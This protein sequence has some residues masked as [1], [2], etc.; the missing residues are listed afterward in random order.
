VVLAHWKLAF[1][2]WR[3]EKS[4]WHTVQAKVFRD[5]FF[6]YV[7]WGSAAADWMRDRWN[8]WFRLRFETAFEWRKRLPMDV[9]RIDGWNVFWRKQ[10]QAVLSPVPTDHFV[11]RC[12]TF[13]CPFEA[14]ET[15]IPGLCGF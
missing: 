2:R 15:V 1:E 8:L 5:A 9:I 4:E 12:T 13:D 3:G 14:L 10:V 11:D 6:V 7:A